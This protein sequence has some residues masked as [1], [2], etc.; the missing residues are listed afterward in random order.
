M[1]TPS[2]LLRHTLKSPTNMIS[3]S[4]QL[5]L[6]YQL[7]AGNPVCA[8]EST[9]PNTALHTVQLSLGPP[10]EASRQRAAGRATKC[11]DSFS[12]NSTRP[13]TAG[14]QCSFQTG[15]PMADCL[16]S[17]QRPSPGERLNHF[18]LQVWRHEGGSIYR[19]GVADIRRARHRGKV[20]D[21]VGMGKVTP[22]PDFG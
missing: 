1:K 11:G 7:L 9:L 18:Q 21:T 12:F 8:W 17:W 4:G 3:L 15:L 5:I 6:S 19:R 14:P 22:P 20:T 10:E 16:I 2:G 13:S